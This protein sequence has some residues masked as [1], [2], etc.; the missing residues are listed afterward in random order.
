MYKKK[1][2]SKT[3]DEVQADIMKEMADKFISCLEKGHIPWHENWNRSNSGFI[4]CSGSHYSFLNSFFLSLED[5]TEGEFVTLNE[6]MARTN[7]TKDGD[8]DKC[9]WNLFIR[10]ENGKIPKSHTIYL[11]HRHKWYEK[12]EKGDDKLDEHGD[13]IVH[14][15][16]MFIKT[17]HVWQVGKEV[18]C[19]LKYTGPGKKPKDNVP[20]GDL[21]TIV[22][23]YQAREGV[24]I[25]HRL[26]TP[27]YD[28]YTDRVM[29]PA[30]KDFKSSE[31]YYSDLF[32]EL[33][34]STGHEKRLNREL[35]PKYMDRT[36][37]SVE[38]LLAEISSCAILHDKGFFH[39]NTD[40]MT[41]AYIQSWCKS[42]RNA[43]KMVEEACKRATKVVNYIYNGKVE[44]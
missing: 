6:L 9:V 4:G 2:S 16:R 12:D 31:G 23:N 36:S 17:Y 44:K 25:I 20:N 22:Q 21:E 30:I 5:C 1:K 15:G 28:K 19:P 26:G 13:K 40:K 7:T 3:M 32:H 29:C 37:Y 14:Y 41:E 18:K 11:Y 8:G 27:C 33:A 35:L 10:D 39:K 43:P 24:K 42:L 34:H 38:E